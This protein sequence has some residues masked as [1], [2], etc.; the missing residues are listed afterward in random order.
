MEI[1][2][3]K[4]TKYDSL[5]CPFCT[6]IANILFM[7]QENVYDVFV[8]IEDECKKTF[9]IYVSDNRYLKEVAYTYD[10]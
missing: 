2:S 6:G 8:C 4:N 7:D 10:I 9:I 3:N 1:D 5:T